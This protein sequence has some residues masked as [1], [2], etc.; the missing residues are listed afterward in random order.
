MRN[1]S[2]LATKRRRTHVVKPYIRCGPIC[3]P[4]C[5]WVRLVF[6][7]PVQPGCCEGGPPDSRYARKAP[8][9]GRP[10]PARPE[11]TDWCESCPAGSS[12]PG[13]RCLLQD[14]LENRS[15]SNR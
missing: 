11:G 13:K 14:S 9:K 4:T 7:P 2:R 15:V 10:L 8:E 1:T 3:A 6:I 5:P 12:P